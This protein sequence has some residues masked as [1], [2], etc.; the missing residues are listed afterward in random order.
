MSIPYN[1]EAEA[2]VVG[3][4]LFGTD[5]VRWVS[6]W[7][8]P[9]DFYVP[10][11]R[12][13]TLAIL[14]LHGNGQKCDPVTVNAETKR[15]GAPVDGADLLDALG[16]APSA[17]SVERYGHIVRRHAVARA[18]MVACTTA[19]HDVQQDGRDPDGIMDAL[20]SEL[21]SVDSHVPTGKPEGYLT[22]EELRNKPQDKRAPWTL[23]G[24]LRQDWRAIFVGPEG[25]GKTLLLRQVA[26]GAASGTDVL[27]RPGPIQPVRTLLVDLENPEDHLMD[28]VDRICQHGER[29]G[30]HT[31]GR[32]AVWHRPGGIDLRKRAWRSQFE[33]ILRDHRPELVCMGPLYKAFRRKSSETEEEAAGELQE[34][35][36]DLRTRHHFALVLEHH[37]P[38]GQQ[39]VRDLSPFGSSL[40]LRWGEIR[41]SLQPP[42]RNFPVWQ[43]E[44]RPFSGS[45]VEHNWPDFLDRSKQGGLPWVGRWTKGMEEF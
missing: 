2:A 38:K 37:A 24:L 17:S 28:W 23:Q 41:M 39:G 21:R 4:C 1:E 6:E 36:D 10:K 8:T 12:N 32:G 29:F 42:D 3:C 16:A 34:I 7:L 20:M 30:K 11:W 43:L 22:F 5:A 31:D 40:W 14:S 25:A 9:G 15:L 44:L 13:A 35:L 33:Q 18:L 45:R 26:V 19:V 27:G